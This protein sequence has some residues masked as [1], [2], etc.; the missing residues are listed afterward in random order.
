MHR[1]YF[2]IECD[3]LLDSVS[4]IVCLGIG[5]DNK[6][7]VVNGDD[8]AAIEAA[9]VELQN[10]DEIIGHN[11]IAFDIPVLKNLFPKWAGP[12]GCVRDTLVMARLTSPDIK[13]S[14]WQT[15]G[16]PKEFIGSH[17]LK[18]WGHR[19]GHLKNEFGSE[20]T[21]WKN[22]QFTPQLA[23]YCKQDIVVTRELYQHLMPKCAEEAL[24]L[25][26]EFA[27]CIAQQV[28]NGF[29]FDKDKANALYAK[30]SSEREAINQELVTIVPPTIIQ[31][32]TKVKE[33][34]F[35]PA[36]RQ[37]IAAALKT[38]HGWE[39]EDFTPSGEAKVDESVL[40]SLEYP[41]AKKLSQYLLLQKRIGM[42]AEGDEAWIKVERSGRIYGSVNHNGAVTGRCT[43]RGPNMA[44]VPSCGSPYG[45]ECRELFT[46]DQGHVLV[47]CDASGLELRCLAHYMAKWDNGDYAKELLQGDIHTANQKAA[48]LPTRNAAKGFIYAFLYGAGPVK[49]GS[50]IGGGA[51]EGKRMQRQ[52]LEKV[53][54]LAALKSAVESA[55]KSRG[56]L[57]GLDGRRLNI[58]S[59]HAALNTLLQSA[60]ALVMKRATIGINREIAHMGSSAKQVAHIHDEIQFSVDPS[61]ADW[62]IDSSKQAITKAGEFFNFRCPLAGEARMGNNWAETH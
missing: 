47:G 57:V 22:L 12:S 59:E 11:I 8:K 7:F 56:Y 13:D 1:V 51:K 19:L 16:F 27:E 29:A 42:L 26:H 4:R 31:M 60:G 17:S 43:H 44:Q 54:A 38:M 23:E 53:P 34:P 46:S 37:Q 3:G 10:A 39:P 52:F 14:D 25:E 32:K 58:R 62:L 6:E 55:A 24:I 48:G 50:L 20:V 40:S 45:K 5:Y 18:A 30:L 15:S 35:N 9:L 49:L 33:I 28:R 61:E 41:I 21:D 2:D 36:S